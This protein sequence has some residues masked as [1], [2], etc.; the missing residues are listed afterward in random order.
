MSWF[1]RTISKFAFPAMN[2]PIPVISPQE[3]HDTC[4]MSIGPL[5]HGAPSDVAPM[6]IEQGFRWEEGEARSGNSPNGYELKDYYNGCP[7]PVHHLGYGI[8]FTQ[9]KAIAKDQF[10]HGSARNVVEVYILKGSRLGDINFGAPRTMMKWWNSNGYDCELAKVDRI[11]ATRALTESLSSRYDA[12]L[13]R[14]KGLHR[15]LDGNQVCV[16]NPDIL[17][18]V[19]KSL[20]QTG[21]IGS[22]VVR[23]EDGMKGIFLGRRPIPPDISQKYH[24]GEPEFLTIKWNK[25]G[26]NSNV[27]P[28]QVDF[29]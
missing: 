1:A 2:A 17:R 23:K 14:G 27:Y 20:S 7:A 15:L 19:D 22:R 11:S 28:S 4:N 18:R 8:Y 6:I 3:A 5:Y 25:G 12:V 16:Y 10:G 13:F 24:N 29:I 26:T 9:V 21:E